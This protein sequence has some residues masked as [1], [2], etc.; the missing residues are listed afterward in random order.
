A[1]CVATNKAQVTP[2]RGA[3]RPEA[4]FTM[5]RVLDAVARATGL[6]PLEVRQRNI[7]PSDAMPYRTGLIYRDSVPVEYD[8]GDYPLM[9]RIATE[10]AE[11]KAWRDRQQELRQQGRLVGL[12]ISSYLEAGGIGPCEGATV[13]IEDTGRVVVF[14]GVNSQGQGHETTFAQVCA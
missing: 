2:Y 10:R 11:Y 8:G 6:D 9:L 7:I 12:G 5:D 4:I 14:V 1:W 3:G 13:K